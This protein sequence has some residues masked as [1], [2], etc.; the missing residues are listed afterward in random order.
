M[1]T[2]VVLSTRWYDYPTG[3]LAQVLGPGVSLIAGPCSAESE[4]QLLETATGLAALGIRTLRVGI[5]KPRTRPGTFEGMGQ[6]GLG[7]LQAV[8]TATGMEV[9]TEVANAQHVEAA[10][11]AGVDRLWI[12]ARTTVSP[13]A[14][15]EIA[16][17]L[18]GTA[19][20]V[21][22]KNPINPELALWIGALERLERLGITD[23]AACHRGFS[24]YGSGTYRNAPQWDIPLELRRRLP[25]LPLL[26]DPSHIAG[27]REK[28]AEVA[29]TALDLGFEGLLIESHRNPP[30]AQSDAAQQLS[31][32][33]LF[34]LLSALTYRQPSSSSTMYHQQ[35]EALRVALDETD[36][37]LLEAVG[38][39]MKLIKDIMALKE[40]YGVQPLRNTREA[41]SLEARMARARALGLR[42]P[43]VRECLRMLYL[44]AV[45]ASQPAAKPQIDGGS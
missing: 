42:E 14:V 12:G 21:L 18:R 30:E 23:L 24:Y 8:R 9:C 32:A 17:A 4:E 22:V 36:A 11:A 44:E 34:E 31:P 37:A 5:W 25:Q 29:Q 19:M 41:E 39:R 13:F 45:E 15:Q 28:V 26:C 33:Q 27:V 16:E 2:N 6:D 20:P 3:P 1:N 7:W 40:Q 35:L 38:R 43:F 10:L